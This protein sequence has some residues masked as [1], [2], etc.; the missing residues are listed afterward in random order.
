M[1]PRYFESQEEYETLVNQ[2]RSARPD[3]PSTDLASAL[4]AGRHKLSDETVVEDAVVDLYGGGPITLDN[5]EEII[6]PLAPET[7]IRHS[8]QVPHPEDTKDD[9]VAYHLLAEDLEQF[10]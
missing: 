7:I 5:G 6:S 2:V 4:V 1:T 8:R 3:A 9:I 10:G